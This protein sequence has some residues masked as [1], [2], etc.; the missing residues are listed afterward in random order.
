MGD[1]CKNCVAN[2]GYNSDYELHCFLGYET[3]QQP[4]DLSRSE[5]ITELE[6]IRK[7]LYPD[8]I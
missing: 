7:N 5:I 4:C 6:H 2:L 8:F 3:H 1:K